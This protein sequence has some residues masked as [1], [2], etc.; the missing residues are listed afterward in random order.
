MY[1]PLH[2]KYR[3]RIFSEVVSQSVT[4]Q[5]LTRIIEEKRF[6]PAYLF[7]G[8]R[9]TGK[10]SMARI[11]ARSANCEHG[12]T[13]TPCLE[14]DHCRSI[15]V[16]NCPDVM[17]INAANHTGVDQMR[18]LIEDMA[19]APSTC[20]RRFYILDEV[21]QLSGAAAAAL[22]KTLEEPPA[23]TSFILATTD[24]QRLLP[25]VR[26][27]CLSFDFH[28]LPAQAIEEQLTEICAQEHWE[29]DPDVLFY[30]AEVAQGGMRDAQEMLDQVSL[31]EPPV[32]LER[33]GQLLGYIRQET[34]AALVQAA[35]QQDR[36]QTQT[37]VRE[38]TVYAEP[39]AIL[40]ALAFFIKDLLVLQRTKRLNLTR[41]L[42]HLESQMLILADTLEF[43]Q[44][45]RIIADLQQNEGKLKE[46]AQTALWLEM[47][48][49]E[50][51]SN[52][53]TAVLEPSEEPEV[54]PLEPVSSSAPT[55]DVQI[56]LEALWSQLLSQL[57]PLA[58]A[59]FRDHGKLASVKD[60]QAVVVLRS[61]GLLRAAE[62]HLTVLQK[63]L[64]QLLGF[65]I[66][67]SV[68]HSE[69]P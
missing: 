38:L 63:T 34:L 23:D 9:G 41:V 20:R 26:S 8:P 46:V 55:P 27:R 42:P 58:L 25:T 1:I 65:S 29:I 3:P 57:P 69:K 16:G 33:C 24:P 47:I 22:L 44:M 37:L 51:F 54:L 48:F 36:L 15:E 7:S 32:T 10:T 13:V 21:H 59:L 18:T 61:Q 49:L 60:Q 62:Q 45:L 40:Q 30:I 28:S 5:M 2:H 67:V 64:S 12:P 14:C 17:E 19:Y 43:G 50:V 56:D 39:L 31:F 35:R 68:T 52:G 11:L 53:V 4:I 6:H 66:Q